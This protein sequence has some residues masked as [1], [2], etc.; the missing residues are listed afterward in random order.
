LLVHF[1]KR[2]HGT[3]LKQEMKEFHEAG[4]V[5]ILEEKELGQ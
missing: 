1:K 4:H 5:V 2:R 3:V